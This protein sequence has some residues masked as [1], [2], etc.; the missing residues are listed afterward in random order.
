[1]LQLPLSSTRLQFAAPRRGS[2]APSSPFDSSRSS[3]AC[4]CWSPKN[5]R[6]ALD[7]ASRKRFFSRRSFKKKKKKNISRSTSRPATTTIVAGIVGPR[8]SPAPRRQDSN[9]SATVTRAAGAADKL[10]GIVFEPFN[11]VRGRVF[12]LFFF[13]K[14][15]NLQKR[16]LTSCVFS[17]FSLSLS[18]SLSLSISLST[19]TPLSLPLPQVKPELANVSRLA[20]SADVSLARAGFTSDCEAALNEQI[21]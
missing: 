21:K 12:S 15:L 11:E 20:E 5:E 1:M 17:L 16:T 8:R 7:G 19:S 4:T 10:S 3:V 9:S 14:P 18:L 2:L 13:F 6:V